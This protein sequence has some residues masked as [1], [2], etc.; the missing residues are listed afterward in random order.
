MAGLVLF[1]LCALTK[2]PAQGTYPKIEASF[3]ITNLTTDPFDY[4][5]TDVRVQI[6]Q[7]DNS[8][9]L[10]PAF[11]DG[12]TTWRVRHSPTMPGVYSLQ[13]V[14]L[15]GAPLTVSGLQPAAWA[16]TGFPT[17][18]G[19]VQVDPA[20]PRRFITSNGRRFFPRRPGCGLEF[21]LLRH[22]E[23]FPQN[24]RGA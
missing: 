10:L 23:H 15:N 4:T 6:S 17:D 24:G 2:I 13:G 20:H 8:T 1:S 11:F 12:G 22:F 14:T 7:P 9:V 18:A 16:V 3:N 19:Y 21:T 5:V